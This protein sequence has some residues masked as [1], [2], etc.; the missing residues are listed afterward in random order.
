[1]V[2]LALEGLA[3]AA[4]MFAALWV[5][6]L[7]KR[8]ASVVDPFWGTGCVALALF[9]YVRGGA[10]T[11]GAL[12]QLPAVALWGVRLSAYLL[13]RNW[14][15]GEDFR[16]RAMRERAPR[17]FPWTS[18]LTVFLLQAGILWV[19]AMPI[20]AVQSAAHPTARS[21]WDVLGLAL[22]VVGFAF[23]AIGDAQMARFKADPENRGKVNDRGLW[24]Y[25]RHPNYFGDAVVWW[26]LFL[27]ALASGAWWT[28][29]GPV[30]MTVLLMKVSGVALLEKTLAETKPAYRDYV[31]RTSAFVPMP[32]RRR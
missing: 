14:G 29:I 4:A 21:P 17:A 25:T 6:G 23:E 3:L 9:W 27:P 7:V 28:A 1:M 31:R 8:D 15:T 10:E 18:L 20:L 12:V 32:P 5:V 2:A 19:V 24:R 30:L 22:F 11:E 13:W 26:G 16:Y